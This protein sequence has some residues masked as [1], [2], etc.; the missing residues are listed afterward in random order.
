MD[1]LRTTLHAHEKPLSRTA[2]NSEAIESRT[3]NVLMSALLPAIRWTVDL[4]PGSQAG[5]YVRCMDGVLDG[6]A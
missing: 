4:T 1:S 2:S 6:L 5:N 3:V